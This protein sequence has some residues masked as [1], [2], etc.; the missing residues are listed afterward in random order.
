[1]LIFLLLILSI[2][3]FVVDLFLGGLFLKINGI[4]NDVD[5]VGI[6]GSSD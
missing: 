4:D 5:I 6:F 1:M 3:V 2:I